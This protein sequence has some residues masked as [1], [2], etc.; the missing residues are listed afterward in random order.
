MPTYVAFLRAINL[1]ATRKFPKADIVAVTEAAGMEEVATHINTGNVLLRTSLRSRAKVE[2]ALEAAY[3]A[4]RGFAVPAIVLTPA[5]VRQVVADAEEVGRDRAEGGRHYVS[6]LKQEPDPTAIA[7]I[8]GASKDG[9]RAVVRGRAVH[10]LLGEEY[11]TATLTNATV[12]KA[13]GVA[14]N[15][16]LTVIRAIAAKWCS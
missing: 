1:G 10:L 15:R 2:A 8:E 7:V 14:T 9:E 5:E 11:H 13:F 12:E 3:E 4:D 6:L 16:N